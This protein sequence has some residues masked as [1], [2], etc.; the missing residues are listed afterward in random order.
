M[1]R[2]DRRSA[3]LDAALELFAAQGFHATAVPSIAERAGVGAGTVYRNFESKEHLVNELYRLWKQR[4]ADALLA[5]WPHDAS[6]RAQIGHA[7]T[8]ALAFANAH[9]RAISFTELHHHADYLDD[10]SEA[11]REA[12]HARFVALIEDLQRA[13]ALRGDVDAD[14][15]IAVFEGVFMRMRH[16]AER[17]ST[18][19]DA[20]MLAQ[21]EQCIWE[22]IRA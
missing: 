6:P 13:R 16:E 5:D 18:S 9:P 7:W 21:A 14:V 4:F 11:L 8:A 20:G 10:Q 2:E 17:C 19:V 22:A 1:S 3:I 15:I 12:L